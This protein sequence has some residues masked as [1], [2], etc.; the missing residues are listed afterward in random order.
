MS[1]ENKFIIPVAAASVGLIGIAAGI[2]VFLNSPQDSKETAEAPAE[3]SAAVTTE[4][5]E[6]T[7][8]ETA[9][10]VSETLPD[11][12]DELPEPLRKNSIS[13]VFGRVK[14]T[15]GSLNIRKTPSST[16]D[17]TGKLEKDS[18]VY[19]SGEEDGWYQIENN[20]RNGGYVHAEYIELNDYRGTWNEKYSQIAEDI[21]EYFGEDASGSG[22]LSF[23]LLTLDNDSIPELIYSFNGNGDGK[24]SYFQIFS[25]D[26]TSL[27]IDRRRSGSIAVPGYNSVTK[28]LCLSRP[29]NADY[30]VYLTYSDKHISEKSFVHS[31]FNY[32][33]QQVTDLYL[34]D[35]LKV[36]AGEFEEQ[37]NEHKAESEP[38]RLN[39]S[40][41]KA[42]LSSASVSYAAP[43]QETIVYPAEQSDDYDSISFSADSFSHFFGMLQSDAAEIPLYTDAAGKYRYGYELSGTI[44][45]VIGE[46][47][48]MYRILYKPEGSNSLTEELY[49]H[50]KYI[51]YSRKTSSW[52]DKY[53]EVIR[54][55]ENSNGDKHKTT[56]TLADMSWD[57]I[58]ELICLT[59][60]AGSDS[61]YI[62]V[63]TVYN[64]LLCDYR[65]ESGCRDFTYYT[66]SGCLGIQSE[67]NSE[68]ITILNLIKDTFKTEVNLSHAKVSS[69][70]YE[71]RIDGDTVSEEEYDERMSQYIAEEEEPIDEQYS[72]L[73]PSEMLEVLSEF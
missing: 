55:L 10:S 15:K 26:P 30:S 1:G 47:K 8:A 19:I 43:E 48:S 71:Y 35:G 59:T 27:Y 44:V 29:S 12:D 5:T 65:M 31:H 36:S 6:I 63:Y 49:V 56:Y 14:T 7:A 13:G 67:E 62:S 25:A 54:M 4:I 21:T 66:S 42:K 39:F 45:Q 41:L 28:E 3:T 32:S 33:G 22:L 73:S 40:A 46:E 20:S 52:A 60:A 68:S 51:N 69:E 18:I 58:P 23:S 16:G 53:D 2:A 11:S 24:E 38:E 34:I 70:E 37:Y 61:K 72:H 57:D 50:K 9:A 17:I 64:G